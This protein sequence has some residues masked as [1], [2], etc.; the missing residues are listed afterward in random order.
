[1]I[2]SQCYF[3]E[4]FQTMKYE[5]FQQSRKSESEVQQKELQLKN[6]VEQLMM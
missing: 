4:Q 1:M 6:Y 3:Y 5:L 2:V